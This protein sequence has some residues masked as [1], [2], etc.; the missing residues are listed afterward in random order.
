M[1]KKINITLFLISMVLA[2]A[3]QNIAYAQNSD[4]REKIERIKLEKMMKKMDLDD[5]TASAFKD[6]YQDFSKNIRDLN[7]KRAKAFMELNKSIENGEGTDSL[8]NTVLD[9]ENQITQARKDFVED[10]RSILTAKQIAIMI[11]FERRFNAELKKLIGQYIKKK[12]NEN[13]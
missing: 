6:K 10:L 5:Q 9:Y 2:L 8:L 3:G 7:Q 1:I 4:I 12:A 13:Q 11:I